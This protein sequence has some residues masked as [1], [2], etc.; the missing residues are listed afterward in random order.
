MI[1]QYFMMGVR[2]VEML[3]I[4][5]ITGI[6]GIFN[7]GVYGRVTCGGVMGWECEC[8]VEVGVGWE[9]DDAEVREPECECGGGELVSLVFMLS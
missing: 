2:G 7:K 8:G 6:T 4:N 1:R 3:E 5:G 9:C